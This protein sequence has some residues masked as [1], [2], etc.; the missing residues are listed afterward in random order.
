MKFKVDQ[1]WKDRN[2]DKWL[3][4]EVG[5]PSHW[6]PV[7]AIMHHGREVATFSLDGLMVLE[8]INQEDL[9]ELV[10]DSPKKTLNFW[11]AR[12]A[13][14]SGKLVRAVGGDRIFDATEFNG[15]RW[16]HY[17]LDSDWEIVEKPKYKTYQLTGELS[18][19]A[20]TVDEKG[21]VV[22]AKNV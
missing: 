9:V 1:V 22:E 19:I 17:E 3:V 11:E 12:N 21:Q 10:E 15:T 20:I 14:L 4:T 8:S 13:V 5:D 18:G 6:Y 2:G 16:S 7:T